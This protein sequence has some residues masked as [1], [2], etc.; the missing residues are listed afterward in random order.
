M[1]QKER[2]RLERKRDRKGEETK[3]RKE[4]K[5]KREINGQARYVSCE[6]SL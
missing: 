4:E 5:R 6:Q 3:E 1:R 2:G